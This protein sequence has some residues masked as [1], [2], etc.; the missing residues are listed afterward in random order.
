MNH[1]TADPV[2]PWWAKAITAGR[3]HSFASSSHTHHC[4]HCAVCGRVMISTRI[5]YQ[6][7]SDRC[8]ECEREFRS[9]K[10]GN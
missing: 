8:P 2:F 4:H 9:I 3:A 1:H 7:V 10:G 6:Y 5:A